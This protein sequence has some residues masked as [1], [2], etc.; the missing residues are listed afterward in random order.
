[1]GVVTPYHHTSLCFILP[2]MYCWYKRKLWRERTILWVGCCWGKMST[3]TFPSSTL[4]KE[5]GRCYFPN[6]FEVKWGPGIILKDVECLIDT[7]FLS[8]VLFIQCTCCWSVH[9]THVCRGKEMERD[10]QEERMQVCSSLLSLFGG[11]KLCKL[12]VGP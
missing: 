1:M 12:P 11:A 5:E 8:S 2:S 3:M 7:L 4:G 9:Y 6:P 10:D